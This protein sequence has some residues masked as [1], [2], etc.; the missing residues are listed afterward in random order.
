M[1]G[2]A[3]HMVVVWHGSSVTY[4]GGSGRRC[5]LGVFVGSDAAEEGGQV[6]GN[7]LPLEWGGDLLVVLLEGHEAGLYFIEAMKVVGREDFAL[8]HGK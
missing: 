8:D 2:I 4:W 7:E 1:S 6:V 3:D 5:L